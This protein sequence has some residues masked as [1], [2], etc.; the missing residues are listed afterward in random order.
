VVLAERGADELLGFPRP[1]AAFA[2][3]VEGRADV[4]VA[5]EVDVLGVLGLDVGPG[6]NELSGHVVGSLFSRASM[7]GQGWGMNATHS[8][9]RGPVR[10][11]RAAAPGSSRGAERAVE[12]TDAVL[13]V[14]VAL[15]VE[16]FVE[17]EQFGGTPLV[18]GGALLVLLVRGAALSGVVDVLVPGGLVVGV[19]APEAGE[20]AHGLAGDAAPGDGAGDAPAGGLAAGVDPDVVV[21]GDEVEGVDA[22]EFGVRSGPGGSCSAAVWSSARRAYTKSSQRNS[23][24]QFGSSGPV[25]GTGPRSVR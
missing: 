14:P 17:R 16:L 5:G 25:T 11:R 18:D 8:S 22:V 20:A 1:G 19:G 4:E 3:L 6:L 21:G 10:R 23:H 15:Q 9:E 2:L 24:R 7:V 13:A 12:G